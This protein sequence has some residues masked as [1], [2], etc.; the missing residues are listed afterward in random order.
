MKSDSLQ[1]VAQGVVLH[2]IAFRAVLG[3]VL[4]TLGY[5]GRLRIEDVCVMRTFHAKLYLSMIYA[6]VLHGGEGRT[7]THLINNQHI[8]QN[9]SINTYFQHGN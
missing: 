8:A 4:G 7:N 2:G 3:L 9:G 5:R 1:N 6:F